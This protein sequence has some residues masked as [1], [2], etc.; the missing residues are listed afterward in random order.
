[1][2]NKKC[3]TGVCELPAFVHHVLQ[4]QS[5][6]KFV[7]ARDIYCTNKLIRLELTLNPLAAKLFNLNFHPLEIVSR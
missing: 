7:F 3:T 6:T 2:N 5:A 4:R 1:M